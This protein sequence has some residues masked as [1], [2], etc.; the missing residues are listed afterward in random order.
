[1]NYRAA[2]KRLVDRPVGQ[3]RLMPRLAP[4]PSG[5]KTGLGQSGDA[6][7]VIKTPISAHTHV[8]KTRPDKTF[9]KEAPPYPFK[10]LIKHLLHLDSG[11]DEFSVLRDMCMPRGISACGERDPVR[12]AGDWP[13]AYQTNFMPTSLIL[14]KRAMLRRRGVTLSTMDAAASGPAS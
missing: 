6:A 4:P 7:P 5:T 2:W 14:L 13:L 12:P 9:K 3:Y 8:S 10:L 1:M 11:V